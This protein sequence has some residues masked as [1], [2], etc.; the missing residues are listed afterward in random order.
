MR[1]PNI[2]A[3]ILVALAATG[4]SSSAGT[5]QQPL[6]PKAAI[7]RPAQ[8]TW[9]YTTVDY[10]GQTTGTHINGI[11]KYDE[12]VGSYGSGSAND[13]SFTS[14]SPYTSFKDINYPGNVG[15]LMTS[16]NPN[17]TATQ[18]P[19]EV[20]YV[21]NP[22]QL[23]GTWGLVNY[24][25]ILTLMEKH[26]GENT[27]DC[28]VMQLLG[29]DDS[30]NA[31]GYYTAPPSGSSGS[32]VDHAFEVQPGESYSDIAGAPGASNMATGINDNGDLVG[33]IVNGTGTPTYEGW[34]KPKGQ[35][36]I[37]FYYN[38]AGSGNTQALGINS[39]E[40]VVGTYVDSQNKQ[41]GFIVYNLGTTPTWQSI[42]EPKGDGSLTV[43]NGINDNKDICGWFK[44]SDGTIH[45]F[46]A[47][48]SGGLRKSHAHKRG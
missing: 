5:G 43:V 14:S 13:A 28:V 24:Q 23:S 19:V 39:S 47:T 32:C 9:T 44:K 18:S 25:G 3:V 10:T 41:H 8:I 20:G 4:C 30:N 22:P 11:N 42:D 37:S 45:G 2:A 34:Y 21:F 27:G 46:V 38:N 48:Y 26:K 17:P 1:G 16:L 35:S 29:V 31:V 40:Y 12:I 33:N 15:T 6:S 7:V 36:A